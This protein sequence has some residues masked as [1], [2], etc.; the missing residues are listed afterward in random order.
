[1]LF[2]I[3]N[4]F[5]LY[6]LSWTGALIEPKHNLSDLIRQ[7]SPL[8]T[9][10]LYV[11][12]STDRTKTFFIFEN[13]HQYNTLDEDFVYAIT[14]YKHIKVKERFSI[15]SKTLVYVFDNHYST[16]GSVSMVFNIDIEGRYMPVLAPYSYKLIPLFFVIKDEILGAFKESD[17]FNLMNKNSYELLFDNF[18]SAIYMDR[19]SPL[20]EPITDLVRI[21]SMIGY[22]A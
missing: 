21:N 7:G 4:T 16:F 8:D 15:E 17:I 19:N 13:E 10:V 6:K 5:F 11:I 12:D 9:F 1:M 22:K 14:K 20:F 18:L 2:I 3:N